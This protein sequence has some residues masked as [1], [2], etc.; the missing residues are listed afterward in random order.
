VARGISVLDVVIAVLLLA[1]LVYLVR[2][3]WQ[4]MPTP[5]AE[6]GHSSTCTSSTSV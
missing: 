4:R 6:P 5:P 3:D 1:L 2:L